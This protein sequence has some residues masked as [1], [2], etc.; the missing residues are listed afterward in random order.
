MTTE[1]LASKAERGMN[2]ARDYDLTILQSADI[3]DDGLIQKLE[4]A[5]GNVYEPAAG[6]Y[7]G[8]VTPWFEMATDAY[9]WCADNESFIKGMFGDNEEEPVRMA[10]CYL[11]KKEQPAVDGLCYSKRGEG[12]YDIIDCGCRGWD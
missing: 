6:I 7:G 9:A 8:A 1:T 11:C 4:F 3:D 10:K 2:I 5:V 12:E